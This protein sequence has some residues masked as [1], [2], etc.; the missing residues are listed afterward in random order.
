VIAPGSQAVSAARIPSLLFRKKGGAGVATSPAEAASSAA[1]PPQTA[2]SPAKRPRQGK[3]MPGSPLSKKPAAAASHPQAASAAASESHAAPCLEDVAAS[4]AAEPQTPLEEAASDQQTEAHRVGKLSAEGLVRL[5]SMAQAARAS[6]AKARQQQLQDEVQ[7]AW[8]ELYRLESR[9]ETQIALAIVQL[10]TRC[11]EPDFRCFLRAFKLLDRFGGLVARMV[12]RKDA[13]AATHIAAAVFFMA[14]AEDSLAL[15]LARLPAVF[16]AL[17]QMVSRET[18]SCLAQ[19]EGYADLE[20]ASGSAANRKPQPGAAAAAGAKSK[21][22]LSLFSK[23]RRPTNVALTSGKDDLK[24]LVTRVKAAADATAVRLG[25]PVA[26][27][28]VRLDCVGCCVMKMDGRVV[29]LSLACWPGST[30]MPHRFCS[31]SCRRN[32]SPWRRWLAL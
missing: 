17:R 13:G 10:A 1:V 3:S 2:S 16:V 30:Q 12:L 19:L 27:M 6:L 24:N 15:L 18:P 9:S 20:G 7:E 11:A 4:A 26:Q 25:V 23:G 29:W 31:S 32:C 14:L 21:K 28:T 22:G 5:E 8:Q